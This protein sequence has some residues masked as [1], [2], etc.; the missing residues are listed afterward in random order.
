MEKTEFV[1]KNKFILKKL[2][3]FV[4]LSRGFTLAFLESS[5]QRDTEQ[6]INYLQTNPDCDDIELVVI[7]C[8]DPQLESL[9]PHIQQQAKTELETTTKQEKVL[10][11][12][13]LE[14]AIGV[15]GDYPTVLVDLNFSRDA[16]ARKLPYPLILVLPDY[17]ITRVARFA[18]DFWAWKSG[19]FQLAAPVTQTATFQEKALIPEI[20]LEKRALPVSQGRF[21][22]L[23]NL[24]ATEYTEPSQTRADL[25]L[26]RSYAYDSHAQYEQAQ[27]DAV[28][29]L[30]LYRQL[31]PANHLSIAETLNQ[32]ARQYESQ[33]KY[34]AAE[35]LYLDALQ[36]LK[37]LLGDHHPD[38]ATSLNN[39]ALLY[40]SQG[41][42]EAAE[43]LYLDA[44]Q[45]LKELLGDRH[46]DVATS[47]NN[48]ALFV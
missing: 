18:P 37:E 26:Q 34:E 14:Q 42:Y 40:K 39:L 10:I 31:L 12:R 38:V 46:P 32:L 33:G 47:L 16:Y 5:R 1:T 6:V 27:K 43:P 44:L 28:A 17:A 19:E 4:T 13:G 11:I 2:L 30:E 3:F 35:P 9:L 23:N 20:P 41:K 7:D 48:L 29:A 36:M 22:L 24:L 15:L 21:D 8:D 45:M 25:L